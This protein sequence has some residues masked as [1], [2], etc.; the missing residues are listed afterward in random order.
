LHFRTPFPISVRPKIQEP[1]VNRCGEVWRVVVA[2]LF[3]AVLATPADAQRRSRWHAAASSPGPRYGAH[4]GYNFDADDAVLGAQ[5]S[6]PISPELD[7]YPSFDVYFDNN[8]TP[9]ALNFDLKF[10]P[11][12]S[13]RVW[14][15]GGGLNLLHAA[16]NTDANLNLLTGL[17]A[18]TGRTRPYVEGKFI[19]SNNSLFQLV[20][21]LS[22]R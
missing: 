19:L 4:I 10:R 15:V 16:G 14:Y 20:F 18:R 8:A 21:G 22:W 1:V 6:W 12:T 2:L 7:F 17:Q 3:I 11:A 13:Y 5:L 9:W